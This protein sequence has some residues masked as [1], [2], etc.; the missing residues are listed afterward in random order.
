MAML[1]R[2]IVLV[3]LSAVGSAAHSPS[4]SPSRSPTASPAPA[5]PATVLPSVCP[6]G[7]VAVDGRC[8]SL[9][10]LVQDW[11]GSHGA[12]VALV[13]DGQS[14]L[15]DI[16]TVAENAVATSVCQAMDMSQAVCMAD[17]NFTAPLPQCC[18]EAGDVVSTA[19]V[20][21]FLRRSR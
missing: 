15:A 6:E 4:A 18:C 14:Y 2:A 10:P 21:F 17:A 3:V 20:R 1:I 7:W 5:Q 13:A 11:N 12:C 19:D 16:R 8:I 9:T